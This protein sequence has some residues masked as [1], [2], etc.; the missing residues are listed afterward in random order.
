MVVLNKS[1]A[2]NT[3]YNKSV[4]CRYIIHIIMLS[5]SDLSFTTYQDGCC[6][7]IVLLG[8][9][10]PVGD[11]SVAFVNR[12]GGALWRISDFLYELYFSSIVTPSMW[13]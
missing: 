12:R 8:F 13:Y 1:R 3:E 11:V 5:W 10:R 9:L 7:R 2:E 4:T 6:F